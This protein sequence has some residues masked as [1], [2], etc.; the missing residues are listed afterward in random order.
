MVALAI[1]TLIGCA[2]PAEDA[3]AAPEAP[4]AVPQI[5]LAAEKEAALQVNKVW[6]ERSR[7]KDAAGI[8]D[9]FVE[10]GWRLTEQDGLVDGRAAVVAQQQK[11]FE[12]N[13]AL[14]EDWGSKDSWIAGSGDLAVERGWYRSDRDGDGEGMPEEGEYVTVLIKKDGVWKALADASVPSKGTAADN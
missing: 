7:A 9:L 11:Y 12:D 6:L 3:E 2:Q 14:V 4:A 8:G 1:A 10:N 13:P 5:D